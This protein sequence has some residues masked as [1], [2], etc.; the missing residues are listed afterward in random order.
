MQKVPHVV[1][2]CLVNKFFLIRFRWH[3]DHPFRSS[4]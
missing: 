1:A 3:A 2:L 4:T